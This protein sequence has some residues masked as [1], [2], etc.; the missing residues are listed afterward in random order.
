MYPLNF[1]GTIH[2]WGLLLRHF[3]DDE[4]GKRAKEV[5]RVPD[6]HSLIVY[7]RLEVPNGSR[8]REWQVLS[9]LS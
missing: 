7:H 6:E 1:M 5:K 2:V 8:G 4:W 9:Q 3:M